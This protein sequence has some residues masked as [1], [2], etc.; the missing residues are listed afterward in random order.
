MLTDTDLAYIAGLID[1]MGNVRVMETAEGTQ[2]PLVS[3]SCPDAALL[4]YLGEVSDM[5]P[6]VT[7][8]TYDRHRCTE[9]CDEPHQHVESRSRR[10]TVTGAKATMILAAVEP[11]L[12]FQ[13]DKVAEVVALGM[14]APRKKA[15]S[16]KMTRLGWPM[17]EGWES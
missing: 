10:W 4:A 9:H 11:Y 14:D 13:K 17:P 3:I 1:V 15:T 7:V 2:L 16:V 8:R 5:Q 12:R 6:F